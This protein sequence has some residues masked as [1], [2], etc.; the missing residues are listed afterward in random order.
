MGARRVRARRIYEIVK[1]VDGNVDRVIADG[2]GPAMGWS[3][4]A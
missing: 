2:I 1:D 4:V 3:L